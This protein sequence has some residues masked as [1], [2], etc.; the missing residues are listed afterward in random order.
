M[1]LRERLAS[2]N[3]ARTVTL[4]GAQRPA[5]VV[6]E[7]EMP[8]AAELLPECFYLEWGITG[9]NAA[10][11]GRQPMCAMEC[12]ISYFTRGTVE[13]GM[14]RGR[15]LGELDRELFMICQPSWT[16]KYDF[17]QA[18]NADLGTGVFWT[19]PVIEDAN[20]GGKALGKDLAVAGHHARI[21]VFFYPEVESL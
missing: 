19:T 8:T 14:D 7:N 11:S 6:R 13:S 15:V 1:A 4:S 5:V 18:P 9:V 10:V 12:I 17:S 16:K 2:L 21:M 3:P 20:A